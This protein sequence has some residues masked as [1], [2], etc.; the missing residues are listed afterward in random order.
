MVIFHSFL[1][2]Y[3]R[4]TMA[5]KKMDGLTKTLG[6]KKQGDTRI[7]GY[8]QDVFSRYGITNKMLDSRHEDWFGSEKHK[9]V[10]SKSKLFR[11]FG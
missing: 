8:D 7:I 4:V 6:P 10:T 5:C 9:D 11:Q 3:Q 2:V 1:Y